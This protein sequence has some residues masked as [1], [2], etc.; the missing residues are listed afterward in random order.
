MEDAQGI[1]I[2]FLDIWEI[3]QQL[4]QA[5]QGLDHSI[6]V[7]RFMSA[8]AGQDLETAQRARRRFEGQVQG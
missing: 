7:Y 1:D 8:C 4:G 2:Q 6:N 3:H 5:Q